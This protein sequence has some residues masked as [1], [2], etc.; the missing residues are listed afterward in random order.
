MWLKR[1]NVATLL[2]TSMRHSSTIS[3][4]R[5]S[6]EPAACRS[7]LNFDFYLPSYITLYSN[8][9][10]FLR[11]GFLLAVLQVQAIMNETSIGEMEEA[12]DSMP[13]GLNDAFEGTLQR[14][15]NQPEKRKLLGM[16]TLMW[17]SHARRPLKTAEL[18]EALAIRPGQTSMN[19]KFHKSQKMMVGCCLSLVTVDKKSSI[20]RLVHYSVQEYFRE[21]HSRIF[22]FGERMI[23]ELSITYLLS[24]PFAQGSR[25]SQPD[26]LALISSHAFAR[27]ATRYW[28]YHLQNANDINVDKLAQTLL[29]SDP[30][31]ACWIQISQYVSGRPEEYWEAKE[32]R[33]RN[34]LHS[35]AA[36]GLEELVKHFL[37][38]GECHVDS[39]TQM[40]T[41]ALIEAAA[42]GQSRV[43]RML[44]N[45]NADLTRE[46]WYGTALHC[47]AEAGKLVSISELLD[48]GLDIDIRDESG[49][50]PLHCA[51]ISGQP[52]AMQLLLDR[53]AEVD[54]VCN[55]KYTPLRYAVVWEFPVKIVRLLLVN[56]ANMEI[57]SR[58]GFTVLHHAAVMNLGKVLIALLDYKADVNA[59]HTYGG[60]ALHFAAER[61]HVH[62][63]EALLNYGAQL[64]AQTY[65]GVTALYSAAEHG[66]YTTVKVLLEHGA[67][68]DIVDD[69]GLS[70]LH[71]A[72]KEK[73]QD[74][75]A[76]LLEAGAE[77][78]AQSK[79]GGTAL[80]FAFENADDGIAKLLLHHGANRHAGPQQFLMFEEG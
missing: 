27:Y 18:S 65:D 44:L 32:A 43:I 24:D 23:A 45:R 10:G 9:N 36:F 35:A 51:T 42:N 37:D 49:R 68:I 1:L 57:R 79:D 21:N 29:R 55:Q 4:R 5:W 38:S 40:G 46:N 15:Q 58:S 75:V 19:S 25:Q 31:R 73:H 77:V 61:N 30:H 7:L 17:I 72:T 67:G 3:L 54:A 60:T 14:I 13:Q 64:D 80:D 74:I 63:V 20:I 52:L 39:R 8:E 56:G 50:T 62:V 78:N 41:T 33:T 16:N 2:T 48:V 71:L 28:G 11:S 47:A 59:K 53:G 26:I 12:L 66:A 76:I 70:P 69:E 34:G 22:P 6:V